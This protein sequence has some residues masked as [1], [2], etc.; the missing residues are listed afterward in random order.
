[1]GKRKLTTT[2]QLYILLVCLVGAVTIATAAAE[3]Y[4][5]TC[6]LAMVA[7]SRT[8]ANQ[9]LSD[10]EASVGTGHHINLR[11]IRFYCRAAVWPGRGSTHRR[12]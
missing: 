7:A 1:M 11:D 8:N 10:G 2:A 3:L 4:S 5:P 9:W 6:R 12:S